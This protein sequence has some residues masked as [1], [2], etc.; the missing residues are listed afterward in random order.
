[1]PACHVHRKS[2][3]IVVGA[4]ARHDLVVEIACSLGK[5]T[6]LM[7]SFLMP[8]KKLNFCSVG[9]LFMLNQYIKSEFHFTDE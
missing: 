1:M 7:E 2:I 5:E 4:W 8:F 9:I 6:E 3:S